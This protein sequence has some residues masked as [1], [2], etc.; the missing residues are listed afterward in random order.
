M[1]Y[2]KHNPHTLRD[3][4]GEP[5]AQQAAER[6]QVWLPQILTVFAR[7]RFCSEFQ[8]R[9]ADG[10]KRRGFFRFAALWRE[11][12]EEDGGETGGLIKREP[13]GWTALRPFSGC[14]PLLRLTS[15]FDNGF[16]V[17]RMGEVRFPAL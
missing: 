2:G 3:S 7:W 13:S 10:I 17:P 9:W 8:R 4:R 15:H 16:T 6:K 12:S 14:H 1:I 5:E 11:K